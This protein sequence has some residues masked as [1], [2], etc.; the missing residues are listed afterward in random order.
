MTANQMLKQKLHTKL[1]QLPSTKLPE[2]LDT[3][4]MHAGMGF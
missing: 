1:E 3:H 2:V 4:F